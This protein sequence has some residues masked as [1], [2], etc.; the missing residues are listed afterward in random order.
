MSKLATIKVQKGKMLR[1]IKAEH[2]LI[3]GLYIET[4]GA[5]ASLQ[6]DN[7]GHCALGSLLVAAGV[8]DRYLLRL[9]GTPGLWSYR[10]RAMRVLRDAYGL[11]RDLAERIMNANDEASGQS[12]RRTRVL[13]AIR[14]LPG[15]TVAA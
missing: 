8:D 5:W 14:R 7:P 12:D 2:D 10:K 11:T 1:V 3:D 15:R 13:R 4:A 9:K 6:C